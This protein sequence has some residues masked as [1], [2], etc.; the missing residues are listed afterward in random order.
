MKKL[1][2]Y[3]LLSFCC[4]AANA[5]TDGFSV[6]TISDAV[7]ARI[8]GKSYPT[9]GLRVELKDLRYLRVKHYDAE[10]NI[11]SGEIIVNKA[12]AN[13]V[14]S[15]F[16][17]L[18]A[19]KYPI[20]SVKLIDEFDANDEISMRHNNSSG[21]CHR[22]VKGSKSLSKHSRGMAVDINTLF[23]PCFKLDPTGKTAYKKGTLQPANA[24]KYVDRKTKYPYTV[25]PEVIKIFK[26]YGFRWGGDW[27]T[28]K[29]YQHFEK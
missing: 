4:M 22:L 5:Q 8:V 18:Y 24:E 28:M 15:I 6:E 27:R 12:I 7:K 16:K 3:I 11:K 13:D 17:E 20:E 9:S 25:T 26:K 23:N 21:Y 29:D 10:G 2:I 14:L 19:M 1:L